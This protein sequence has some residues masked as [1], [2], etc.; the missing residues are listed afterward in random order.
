MSKASAAS[1]RAPGAWTLAM[2]GPDHADVGGAQLAG[3]DVDDG[4]AGEEQ[5]ERGE[6]LGGGHGTGTDF[7]IDGV[8][9]VGGLSVGE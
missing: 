5:V 1:V 3:G 9:H 4:A 2:S 6:A 8:V 7:G